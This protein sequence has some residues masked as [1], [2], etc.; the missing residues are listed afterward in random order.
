LKN[1]FHYGN[2][3]DLTHPPSGF[4]DWGLGFAFSRGFAARV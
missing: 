4:R 1:I 2:E 3:F